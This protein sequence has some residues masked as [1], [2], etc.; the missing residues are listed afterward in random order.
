MATPFLNLCYVEAFKPLSPSPSPI[1]GEGNQKL[2]LLPLSL[3][4]R[5][6][7][8]VRAIFVPRNISYKY[9]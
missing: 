3:D 9:K 7:W 2:V 8:G 6:G 1:K 4:G 5:G